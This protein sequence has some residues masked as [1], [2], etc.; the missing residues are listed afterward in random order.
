MEELEKLVQ[1]SDC[2]L[3]VGT[4]DTATGKLNRIK[5]DYRALQA[6]VKVMGALVVFSSTPT[7]KG[8]GMRKR[9]LVM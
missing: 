7:V 8:K 6:V 5:T 3:L 1:S 9:V 2:Y 4:N